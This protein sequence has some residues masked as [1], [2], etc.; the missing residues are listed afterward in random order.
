MNNKELLIWVKAEK[1]GFEESNLYSYLSKS[2][3]QPKEN[4]HKRAELLRIILADNHWTTNVSSL[5]QN[6]SNNN[7]RRKKA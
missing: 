4:E 6:V 3:K 7:C 2:P 5:F 1:S